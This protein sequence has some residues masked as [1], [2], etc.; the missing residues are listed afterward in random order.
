MRMGRESVLCYSVLLEEWNSGQ[1][2]CCSW[3]KSPFS[4]QVPGCLFH[5]TDC[6]QPPS[7]CSVEEPQSIIPT[8]VGSAVEK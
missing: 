6:E 4:K 7:W 3:N 1:C 2:C 5:V 8:S